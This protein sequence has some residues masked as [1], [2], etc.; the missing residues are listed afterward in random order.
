[1]KVN[2]T[3]KINALCT[4]I[5]VV[6]VFSLGTYFVH[7][8]TT[9]LNHALHK[10]SSVLLSSLAASSEYPVFIKDVEALKRLVKGAL[11]QE[12]I[13]ACRIE[14]NHGHILYEERTLAL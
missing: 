2:L 13:A 14:D 10:R 1:M 8:K 3:L 9:L 5:I 6:L 4:G 7:Q 12:D 11:T